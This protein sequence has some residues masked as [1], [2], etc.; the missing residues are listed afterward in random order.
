MNKEQMDNT[1]LLIALSK[2]L[3]KQLGDI[4]TYTQFIKE[5]VESDQTAPFFDKIF[6]SYEKS[7]LFKVLYKIIYPNY[8][9]KTKVLEIY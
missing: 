2:I 6:Q 7:L 5:E 3:A 1:F 9:K 4:K 8:Q